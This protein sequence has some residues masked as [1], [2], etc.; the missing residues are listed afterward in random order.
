MRKAIVGLAL[1]L[2][3]SQAQAF[4]DRFSWASAEPA[5]CSGCGRHTSTPPGAVPF[6]VYRIPSGGGTI[7]FHTKV[8]R[9][10]TAWPMGVTA[11]WFTEDGSPSGNVCVK[12]CAG[13]TMPGQSFS[14]LD[15]TAACT[16]TNSTA[17]GAQYESS[18][19][20]VFTT[21]LTPKDSTN[22]TPA[23]CATTACNSGDLFVSLERITSGSCSGG[24]TNNI[25]FNMGELV[26]Q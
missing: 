1:L 14:D 9:E 23:A 25:E 5:T 24:S 16:T 19:S 22:P 12:L 4:S 11:S 26:Y 21:P 10:V 2:V 6:E 20:F 17:I 13:V 18:A 8:P 3:A 7:V 15:M